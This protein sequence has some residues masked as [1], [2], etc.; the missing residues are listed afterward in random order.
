M[1]I[2]LKK[3]KE[4]KE[5]KSVGEYLED[6]EFVKENYDLQQFLKSNIAT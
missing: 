3:Q 5:W 6:K 4:K 1:S 2:T